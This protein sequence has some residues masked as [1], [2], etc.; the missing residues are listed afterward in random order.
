M[1]YIVGLAVLVALGLAGYERLEESHNPPPPGRLVDIGG[2]RLHIDCQG[3]GN[4]T[5]IL[6]AGLGDVGTISW[7]AVQPAVAKS[8][9]VCSYDRGGLGWSDASPFRRDPTHETNELHTLLTVAGIQPPYVVVGHS[10]GGDLAR[11]LVSRFPTGV[12]GLVLVEAA[13]EDQWDKIPEAHADW[14]TYLKTCRAERIKARFGLVRLGHDSV[15]SVAESFSYG[16]KQIVA[17]CGEAWAILSRGPKEVKPARSFGALPLI[18]VSAGKNFWEKAETWA[19][20]Q[21]MQASDSTMSSC[22]AR[23]IAANAQHE[24]EHDQPDVVIAQVERMVSAVRSIDKPLA[25]FNF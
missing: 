2:Y 21:A 25:C 6:E 10:Y 23:V 20:W 8:T 17:T 4:P 14:G 18:V 3:T 9:R 16:P 24:V 19:V 22:S 1:A 13:N 12:V 7:S 15:P 5:V 11:L